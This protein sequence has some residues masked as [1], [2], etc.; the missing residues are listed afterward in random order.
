[1]RE[2][3]FFGRSFYV[4]ERV[5]A[6]RP[7]TETLIEAALA[8]ADSDPGVRRVHDLC[9]GSGCIA[10]TIAA[11]R[12]RLTVSASDVSPGAGEVFAV[13]ARRIGFDPPFTL[14]SLFDGLDGPFDLVVSNPPYLTDEEVAQM[15][16]RGLAEP[17]I[18]LRGG[19]DG[20]DFYRTIA[21][22]AKRVLGPRGCLLLEAAPHQIDWLAGYLREQ[23]YGA[24]ATYQD[25]AGRPRAVL[26][27]HGADVA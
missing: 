14:C 15:R 26:V 13:N 10:L 3:E 2:K 24:I 16:L 21:G 27:R 19:I 1:M 9:T 20:T 11:E 22:E 4:D 18:A 8:L 17:E 5:L 25:L 23:G 12:P 7:D 6:P